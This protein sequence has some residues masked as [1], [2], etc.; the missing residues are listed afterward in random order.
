MIFT[1]YYIQWQK[2]LQVHKKMLNEKEKK[3]PTSF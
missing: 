3:K 2:Y 1:Q